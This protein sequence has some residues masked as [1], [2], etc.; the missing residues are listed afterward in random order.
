MP[1]PASTGFLEDHPR[2]QETKAPGPIAGKWKFVALYGYG[3]VG[4]KL[5]VTLS[6]FSSKQ[7]TP[8]ELLGKDGLAGF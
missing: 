3:M 8:V 6:K 4:H 2:C 1:G 7:G 5:Q